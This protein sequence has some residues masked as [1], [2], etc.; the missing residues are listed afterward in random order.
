MSNSLYIAYIHFCLLLIIRS[1]WNLFIDLYVTG[2][3]LE[4]VAFAAKSYTMLYLLS[5][6]FHLLSLYV[7]L[8]RVCMLFL[9]FP[10]VWVQ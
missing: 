3:A 5:S 6:F 9:S 7:E 4:C 2:S 10:M 8:R 1:K